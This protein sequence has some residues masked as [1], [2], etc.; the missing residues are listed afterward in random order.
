[1]KDI[2]GLIGLW[3]AKAPDLE[4]KQKAVQETFAKHAQIEVKN[5][6]ISKM[7]IAGEQAS[8]R[9]VVDIQAT[10]AKT[11]KPA[12]GWGRMNRAL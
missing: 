9:V 2:E 1:M 12:K 5:V 11:G 4:A 6:A 10:E 8:A 7:R 3:S